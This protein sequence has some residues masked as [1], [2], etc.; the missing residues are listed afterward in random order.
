MG[1]ANLGTRGTSFTKE[2]GMFVQNCS[3]LAEDARKIFDLYWSIDGLKNLPKK[4]PRGLESKINLK[5]PLRIL[6]SHD[7]TIYNVFLGSS[8]LT[9]CADGRT[10]D[11]SAILHVINSATEYIY[12]AVNEY[13]P[14]DLW[15]RREP[16]T[17]IDDQIR[18]GES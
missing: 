18:E 1:S 15:K 8:P 7:G 10:D 2:L 9:L 3:K 5:H 12:I 11:L 6:N 4:Y 17:V 14:M 13:I 16:W